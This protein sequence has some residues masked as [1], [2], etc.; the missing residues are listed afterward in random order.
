MKAQISLAATLQQSIRELE[1]APEAF[2]N[3][4]V[5]RPSPQPINY[6][7]SPEPEDFTELD[8]D[9]ET[10]WQDYVAQFAGVSR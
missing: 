4:Q 1:Q 2:L 10:G 3:G 5:R 9:K 8:G 6:Y 7:P